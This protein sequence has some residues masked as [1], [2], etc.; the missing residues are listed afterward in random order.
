MKVLNFVYPD[1]S[2]IKYKISKFP[3][4]MIKN[5]NKEISIEEYNKRSEEYFNKAISHFVVL[6]ILVLIIMS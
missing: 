4:M 6:L 2:D 3:E 1:K 5:P